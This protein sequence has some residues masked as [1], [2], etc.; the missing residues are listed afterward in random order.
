MWISTTKPK[1]WWYAPGAILGTWIVFAFVL[2][3]VIYLQHHFAAKPI[4]FWHA[5]VGPL[6][7]YLI[8]AMLTPLIFWVAGKLPFS[9]GRIIERSVE[10]IFLCAAFV[11][12]HSAASMLVD[13]PRGYWWLFREMSL[14]DRVLTTLYSD[15]WMYFSLVVVW[16]L[17]VYQ[18]KFHE[19]ELRAA[20]LQS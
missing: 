6:L 4:T 1:R 11:V 12:A 9:R 14:W 13:L 3:C 2:S 15:I 16:N 5:F 17:F 19:R 18:E 7:D 8:F 20:T 10:H